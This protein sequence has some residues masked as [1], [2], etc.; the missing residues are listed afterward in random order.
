LVTE[1]SSTTY[2]AKGFRLRVGGMGEL[3]LSAEGKQAR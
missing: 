1:Y 2:L 3:Q